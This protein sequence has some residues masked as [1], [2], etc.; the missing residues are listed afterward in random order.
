MIPSCK[1]A[2]VYQ[3]QITGI[4]SEYIVGDYPNSGAKLLDGPVSSDHVSLTKAQIV[5][6]G[7]VDQFFEDTYSIFFL[8]TK[9]MVLSLN[10]V[11][12]S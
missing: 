10:Y 12:D 6:T 11:N 1:V 9:K 4:L 3:P 2:R 7:W 8:F 5:I